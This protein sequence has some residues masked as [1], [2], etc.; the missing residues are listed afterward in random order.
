MRCA[1]RRSCPARRPRRREQRTGEL[2]RHRHAAD[3]RGTAPP[4]DAAQ[5]PAAQQRHRRRRDGAVARHRADPGGRLRRV[6]GQAALADAYNSANNSPNAIYELLLGGVLSASLVPLFTK[7][8]EDHD[9]EATSAVVTVAMIVVTGADGAGVLAAPVIFHLFSL[10]VDRRRRRVPRRRHG[11]GPHLPHPDL[12]LRLDRPGHRA[13]PRP[14]AVLRRGLGAGAVQRRDHR[15][16]AAG[17][18]RR[19]P[20]AHARRDPH[21]PGPALDAAL[22]ATVGIAMMA[23]ALL[24]AIRMA[25]VRLRWNPNF[26]HPAVK[27]LTRCPAGR[28]ATSSPTRSPRSRSST[29]P[30]PAAVTADAYCQGVHLLRAAARPAGHVDRD[31]VHTRDG[32]R[33]Q[34]PAAPGVH[35]LTSLGIRLI[36]LLTFPAGLLMFVLRRPIIGFV[37]QHGNFAAENALVTAA[38]SAASPSGWSGSPSTCSPCAASTR[39]TTRAHRSSSTCSRTSSTSSWRSSSSTASA[40]SGSAWRS[41]SPTCCAVSGPCRSWPTRCPGFPVA[42]TSCALARMA[43]ATLLMAEAVWL[44]AS[45]SAATGRGRRSSGSSSPAVVGLAVYVGAADRHARPGDRPAER[46]HPAQCVQRRRNVPRRLAAM[47]KPDRRSGGTTWG[48]SS[49]ATSSAAPTRRCSSS[50]RWPSPQQQHRRLKEQAANVIASQKQAEIRLNGKMN[51]LE[52]LNANAR[53]A[54]VMAADA[55]KAGDTDKTAQY[56]RPRRPSPTS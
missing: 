44:V 34:A 9:D 11:A 16:A 39:T 26:R 7:Q 43:L 5:Q 35:R 1:A 28:S 20:R 19:R 31:D 13:A 41:R 46:G 47:F 56:T 33:R 14:P 29:S 50:R 24:P 22:G 38:R 40:C 30:T 49:T 51:E 23:L 32:P 25:D 36:A 4:G 27:L 6:V 53:Q 21:R 8:A 48:P 54:L 15:L 3:R 18:P 2:A 45:R 42:P 10:D 37:L 17:P 12:L 52:K 55:Q